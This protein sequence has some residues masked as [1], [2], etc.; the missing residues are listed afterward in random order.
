M[1]PKELEE[2]TAL[3]TKQVL[4]R[5]QP[6]AE[7]A[8]DEGKRKLLVVGKPDRVPKE[9]KNGAVIFTIEDTSMPNIRATM[10]FI[11]KSR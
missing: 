10:R 6:G 1:D 4:A 11:F 2:L 5:M 9:V 7:P 3:I 8:C